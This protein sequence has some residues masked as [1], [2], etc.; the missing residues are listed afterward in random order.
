MA[1]LTTGRFDHTG[2]A[3]LTTG[4]FDHKPMDG[5]FD[6]AVL[7]T[8]VVDG[9]FDHG[10]FAHR[11]RGVGRFDHG[12]FDHGRFAHTHSS[13]WHLLAKPESWTV[14]L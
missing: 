8:G 11:A 4:W 6:H 10:R 3:V 13:P 2:L 9:R 12:R 7:T 14:S 1:I 5:R